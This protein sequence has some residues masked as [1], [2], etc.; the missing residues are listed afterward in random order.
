MYPN[1]VISSGALGMS[2]GLLITL[3]L[4][5]IDSQVY[6]VEAQSIGAKKDFCHWQI[7][8]MLK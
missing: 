7:F 4:P 6:L 2:M 5:F 8:S 3:S 1:D